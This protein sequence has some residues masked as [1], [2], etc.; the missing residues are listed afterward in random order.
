MKRS[1]ATD[2]GNSLNDR[3]QTVTLSSS[4][5]ESTMSKSDADEVFED[6]PQTETLSDGNVVIVDNKVVIALLPSKSVYL[7]GKV[8]IKI[9]FGQ[10]E[11]LGATIRSSDPEKEVFS[12]RGYSLLSLSA[13]SVPSTAEDSVD[14][15]KQKL[16]QLGLKS[17]E[18]RSKLTEAAERGATVIL[19]SKLDAVGDEFISKHLQ[20]SVGGNFE[21]F[22]RDSGGSSSRSSN[23]FSEA[24]KV[25]DVN[26]FVHTAGQVTE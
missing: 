23:N 20:H 17:A 24:E 25:L 18:D 11:I 6:V 3:I 21:L 4:E 10:V 22:G 7:K 19:L 13:Q 1:K 9:L 26:L 15:L 8:R 14:T 16:S 2:R 12:P 5:S